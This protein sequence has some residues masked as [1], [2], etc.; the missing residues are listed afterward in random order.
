MKKVF[1]NK[2]LSKFLLLIFFSL[3]LLKGFGQ[4]VNCARRALAMYVPKYDGIDRVIEFNYTKLKKLSLKF[5][6]PQINR[7]RLGNFFGMIEYFKNKYK[8][9]F[10]FMR[11]YIAVYPEKQ[12]VD[13]IVFKNKWTLIFAPASAD[14]ANSDLA[15]YIFRSNFDSADPVKSEITEAE[16]KAWTKKFVEL[17]PYEPFGT[18][19]LENQYPSATDPNRVPSDTR[20]VTYDVNNL[21]EL[22][23]AWKCLLS[24]YD[25]S[26]HLNAYLGS[27]GANGSTLP[28]EEGKFMNRINIQ[29]ELLYKDGQEFY[30][31]D[32]PGFDELIK[33]ET[34]KAV[35]KGLLCPPHCP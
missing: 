31:D 6:N 34:L 7:L 11:V 35:D 1:P 26:S 23:T 9:E 28:R 32:I 3:T 10:K 8:E 33:K 30:L 14:D 16:M 25:L 4:P 13:P 27:Y 17:M 15:Y 24:S 21:I 2:L 5:E 12:S 18:S 20:Y 22:L 19:E 29:F